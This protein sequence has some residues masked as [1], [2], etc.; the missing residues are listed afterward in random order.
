MTRMVKC[1]KYGEELPGLSAPP[2]PGPAGE[3]IF[4][5]VSARAWEEWQAHQT[6]LIN[7]RQLSLMDPQARKFLA[8][9]R[10]R[11]LDNEDFARAEHYVPEDRKP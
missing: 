6:R 7:E 2:F 3:R 8:E 9:Q 4:E 10:E 5:T 1:R 11:F